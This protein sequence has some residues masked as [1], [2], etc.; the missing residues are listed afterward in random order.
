MESVIA[1]LKDRQIDPELELEILDSRILLQKK[2]NAV[3]N[4]TTNRNDSNTNMSEIE[5]TYTNGEITEISPRSR[6]STNTRPYDFNGAQKESPWG[7]SAT[8]SLLVGVHPLWGVGGEGGG[9]VS[10]QS[11]SIFDIHSVSPVQPYRSPDFLQ[12]G[13]NSTPFSGAISP[14]EMMSTC[15]STVH[16]LN[17]IN[18]ENGSSLFSADRNHR[19]AQSEGNHEFD[20]KTGTTSSSYSPSSRPPLIKQPLVSGMRN[21]NLTQESSP[22]SLSPPSQTPFRNF[23]QHEKYNITSTVPGPSSLRPPSTPLPNPTPISSI[24]GSSSSYNPS[25]VAAINDHDNNG[26]SS[27]NTNVGSK[28]SGV[29][30]ILEPVKEQEQ[31][32]EGL[33]GTGGGGGGGAIQGGLVFRNEFRFRD[34]TQSEEGKGTFSVSD[35]LPSNIFETSNITDART[36]YSSSSST[37]TTQSYSPGVTDLTSKISRNHSPTISTAFSSNKLL[38]AKM[39]DYSQD[40][41]SLSKKLDELDIKNAPPLDSRNW[42]V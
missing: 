42:H 12:R 16:P 38:R 5:N 23:L 27:P 3:S 11:P 13:E 14:Q 28:R 2:H 37:Y 36:A 17:G 15:N 20:V 41:Q 25:Q 7:V 35:N 6:N 19:F 30:N 10:Q 8:S 26:P 31:G 4:T 24:T 39:T 18:G 9:S 32:P 21:R 34:N 29:K 33:A 22:S 40:L 1:H